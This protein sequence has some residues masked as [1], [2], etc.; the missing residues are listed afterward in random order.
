MSSSKQTERGFSLLNYYRHGCHTHSD[1]GCTTLLAHALRVRA[2]KTRNRCT[3]DTQ[4]AL[5]IMSREI[6]DAGFN[7]NGN[8][9]VDADQ[10]HRN[11]DSLKPKQVRPDPSV[12]RFASKR[13]GSR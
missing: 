11:P 9:L 2:E 3:G 10:D 7:I 6:A 5:N 4:R 12:R 1:D 8:G 13:A